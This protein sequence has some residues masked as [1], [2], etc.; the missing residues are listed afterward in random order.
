M[1]ASASRSRKKNH[2]LQKPTQPKP[3]PDPPATRTTRSGRG[4][5][6]GGEDAPSPS[7]RRAGP[8]I[9]PDPDAMAVDGQAPPQPPARRGTAAAPS[10]SQPRRPPPPASSSSDDDDVNLSASARLRADVSADFPY[11]ARLAR[12]APPPVDLAPPPCCEEEEEEEAGAPLSSATASSHFP[13]SRFGTGLDGGLTLLQL[14]DRLPASASD[15][16]P[17]PPAAGGESGGGGGASAHGCASLA[18]LPPGVIGR[19]L[20]LRSGAVKVHIGDVEYALVPGMP[21]DAL[22]AGVRLDLGS[23]G[24]GRGGGGGG[25]S[26]SRKSGPPSASS[27]PV[28]Q[29][30]N[31]ATLV[32]DV[33]RLLAGGAAPEY[34]RAAGFKGPRALDAEWAARGGGGHL[35]SPSQRR[36]VV[37]SDDDEEGGGGRPS[38]RAARV[39]MDESD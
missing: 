22:A 25:G 30:V 6:G 12:K 19:V 17:P 26:A 31:R 27:A 11:A 38:G 8:A 33:G 16:T 2:P 21:V 9:K 20:L 1:L 34:R 28:G 29:V 18:D 13:L 5:G 10:P 24:S 23:G 15:R 14:P 35:A 32:P 36:A 4:A 7:G 3:D 39:V 37:A